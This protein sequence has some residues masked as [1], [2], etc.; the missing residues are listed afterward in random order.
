MKKLLKKLMLFV[1]VL[2][3]CVIPTV[4]AAPMENLTFVIST[5]IDP[6][7]GLYDAGTLYNLVGNNWMPNPTSQETLVNGVY[8]PVGTGNNG[9][10]TWGLF[11]VLSINSDVRGQVFLASP[12]PGS[13]QIVGIFG[14]FVDV[15]IDKADPSGNS[16]FIHS[17]GGYLKMYMN[18]GSYE[19]AVS[20]G[21]AASIAAN[22]TTGTLLVDATGHTEYI[23]SDPT[24]PYSLWEYFDFPHVTGF[25]L[26]GFDVN[27]A[28][29]AWA[30]LDTNSF[31]TGA[32]LSI[33]FSSIPSNFTN[34]TVQ[35]NGTAL[36]LQPVPEPATMLLLGLGLFGLGIVRRFRKN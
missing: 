21:S 3:F 20:T 10:D 33:N 1:V 24:K 17:A 29:S 2:S 9:V 6:Y 25:G 8:K 12:T 4:Y 16:S 14:D 18:T 5:V 34:W 35:A 27:T 26:V 22:I 30:G 36:G 15:Q 23:N 11:R 19:T 28:T 31:G 13:Q 7:N 32:D